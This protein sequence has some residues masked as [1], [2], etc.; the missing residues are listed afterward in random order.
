[1]V[2]P[3]PIVCSLSDSVTTEAT[4]VDAKGSRVSAHESLPLV[5]THDEMGMAHLRINV[6]EQ[7]CHSTGHRPPQI[8]IHWMASRGQD[9]G[10]LM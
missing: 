1:M 8:R 7:H 2:S 10:E 9:L 6:L 5:I 4:V 3:P